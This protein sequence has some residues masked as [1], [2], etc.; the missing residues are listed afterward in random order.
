VDGKAAENIQYSL[1]GDYSSS[2]SYN[3]DRTFSGNKT[4]VT[5]RA[6]GVE[7][8]TVIKPVS[9]AELLLGGEYRYYEHENRQVFLDSMGAEI[10]ST[11]IDLARDLHSDA[12]FSELQYRPGTWIKLQS[13]IRQEDNSLFGVKNIYRYGVVLN[14]AEK[15]SIKFNRGSHFKAPTMNDLFWPDDGFAKGN[16]LLKPETGWHTDFS[17]DQGLGEK[18]FVTA[19]Y[20]N[21]DV[22]NKIA[23][24]EDPDQ[25]ALYGYNY[26]VPTNLDS[27]H[28]NGMELGARFGPFEKLSF[29]LDY[30]LLHAVEE[31]AGNQS[32]QSSYTPEQQF[33]CDLTYKYNSEWSLS[34]SVMYTDRR[35]YYAGANHSAVPTEFLP[36]YWV[37]DMKVEKRFNDHFTASLSGMNLFDESY[38]TRLSSFF[39]R[40]TYESTLSPY[41][42]A[43]RSFLLS[44]TYKY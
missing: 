36:S 37:L 40:K 5:N 30:T 34:P 10:V 1:K 23:W 39:D 24:A 43:G 13:G 26:W 41:P 20:F 21:W 15:T 4:W 17:V 29:S 14:P 25:P 35:P 7:A 3:Y 42:G 27:Y 6:K 22:T 8:N 16:P 33:K 32:R 2:K 31:T 28:A 38:A 9:G 19:G 11:A 18:V 12:L 44:V